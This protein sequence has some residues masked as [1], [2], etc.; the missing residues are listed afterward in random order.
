MGKLSH[1][2]ARMPS[3]DQPRAR[4]SIPLS[5]TAYTTKLWLAWLHTIAHRRLSF[6]R[7]IFPHYKHG[8]G[9]AV[10]TRYSVC[11]VDNSPTSTQSLYKVTAVIYVLSIRVLLA[12]RLEQKVA[13]RDAEVTTHVYTRRLAEEIFTDYHRLEVQQAD[14]AGACMHAG[15]RLQ[16]VRRAVKCKL[17]KCCIQ[18]RLSQLR[19]PVAF[20][21][22]G[23]HHSYVG[24]GAPRRARVP[25]VEHVIHRVR[26][27]PR[28]LAMGGKVIKSPSPLNVLKDTYDH[29]CY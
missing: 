5:S 13:Q 28:G 16:S 2:R 3:P 18:C 6:E 23:D 24:V 11:P 8:Y 22:R 21:H 17:D 20:V 1:H 26:E 9:S 29:S 10:S 14:E 4:R 25:I 27:Q 12:I 7:P 15:D 19:P